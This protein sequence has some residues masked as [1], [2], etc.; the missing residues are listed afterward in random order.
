V[1][2]EKLKEQLFLALLL[3]GVPLGFIFMIFHERKDTLYGM[4]YYLSVY[5]YSGVIT[6]IALISGTGLWYWK[7]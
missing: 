4:P 7:F 3:I 1:Y 5:Y 6:L 2:M